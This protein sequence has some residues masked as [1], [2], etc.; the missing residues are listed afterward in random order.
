MDAAIGKFFF[1]GRAYQKMFAIRRE[2]G[3]GYA[4]RERQSLTDGLAGS[5]VPHLEFAELVILGAMRARWNKIAMV[6][7]LR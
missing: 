5:R 2:A 4:V 3:D 7:A 1:I 6:E